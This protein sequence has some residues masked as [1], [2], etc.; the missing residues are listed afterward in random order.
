LT[1]SGAVLVV[2]LL[3]GYGVWSVNG[4][5]GVEEI[6]VTATRP[7]PTTSV[8]AEQQAAEVAAAR[9]PGGADALAEIGGGDEEGLGPGHTVVPD[10]LLR[11]EPTLN[12]LALLQLANG[13]PVDLLEGS[14][15]A[16]GYDWVRVRL[17]DGTVGWIIADG[18]E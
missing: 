14:A 11:D 9:T 4:G 15:A 10:L 3:L 5:V 13:T 8:A 16:D 18:V 1:T 7:T 6:V 17:D 2:A 12:A